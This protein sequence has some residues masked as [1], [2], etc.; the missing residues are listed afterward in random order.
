MSAVETAGRQALTEMRSLLDVLRPATSDEALLPQPALADLPALMEQV[1]DAGVT[2]T[3]KKSDDLDDLTATQQLTIYRIVQEALTN[4]IKHAGDNVT[5][6]V[7][8]RGTREHVNVGIIDDGTGVTTTSPNGHGIVGMRE[9]AALTGGTLDVRSRQ[10]G[11]EVRAR[12][13]R[14]EPT[15]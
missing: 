8:I 6:I 1:R 5:V 9:R 15:S 10:P 3:L 13:P 12:F 7:E 14:Q 2:V 4:V 11:F